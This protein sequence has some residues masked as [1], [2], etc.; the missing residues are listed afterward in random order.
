MTDAACR[1]G[2]LFAAPGT[3]SADAALTLERIGLAAARRYP[4]LESRW[5]YTSRGVRRKLG[6]QGQGI[7]DAEEALAAMRRDGFTHVAVL[8]LHLS[9]GME[10]GEL[11][12]TVAAH[13]RGPAAFAGISLGTPLLACRG[14]LRRA[15]EIVLSGLPAPLGIREGVVLVAHGSRDAQGRETF[16]AAAA[17][18]REVDRRL[19]MGVL[20]G[21]PSLADI[22]AE[23]RAASF[24]KVWLLPFMVAAGYSARVEIAGPGVDSWKSAIVAAGIECEPV[25][26]GLGDYPGIVNM[27]MD[28]LDCL[29]GELAA[30]PEPT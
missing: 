19:L 12:E 23:C 25:I 18:S 5:A 28:Q 11:A 16:A 27:W 26:T 17:L 7:P 13:V 3:T 21:A 1:R 4:S 2:I 20:L 29:L 8:P 9:D 6:A 22:V 10:F 24:R 30:G 14:D 15:F